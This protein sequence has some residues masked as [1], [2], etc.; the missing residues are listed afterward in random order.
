[1]SKMIFGTLFP[2]VLQKYA[3]EK[4]FVLLKK[5]LANDTD[6]RYGSVS[7][8]PEAV[9]R[10]SENF[11]Q[12]STIRV[13]FWCWSCTCWMSCHFFSSLSVNTLWLDLGEG[14]VV[15]LSCQLI[16]NGNFRFRN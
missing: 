7:F 10:S 16:P 3:A 11:R 2:V 8:S 5:R 12:R 14:S 4:H 9:L 1:M 6:R 15:V 13:P